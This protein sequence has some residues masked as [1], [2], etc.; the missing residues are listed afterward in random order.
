MKT[1]PLAVRV[2]LALAIALERQAEKEAVTVADVIRHI[3]ATSQ[4]SQK[5][6]VFEKLLT[7]ESQVKLLR[8][9]QNQLIQKLSEFDIDLGEQ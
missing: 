2:P 3:L 1:K 6:Q 9:G 8:Q 5:D 7:I 4:L